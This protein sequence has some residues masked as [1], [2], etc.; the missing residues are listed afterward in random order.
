MDCIPEWFRCQSPHPVTLDSMPGSATGH[1]T[2][3]DDMMSRPGTLDTFE[4]GTYRA[5]PL[6]PSKGRENPVLFPTS[7]WLG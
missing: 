5:D 2:P 3:K 7:P 4:T 6:R 1:S